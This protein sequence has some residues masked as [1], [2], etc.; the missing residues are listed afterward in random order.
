MTVSRSTVPGWQEFIDS[1]QTLPDR[2]LAKLPESRRGDPQIQ[3]EVARLALESLASNALVAIAGDGDAPQFLPAIGQVLNVGQPNADTVYKSCIITPGA[4]YRL[5]G[6]PGT[7]ALA[8]MA[9]IIPQGAP[10]A[11]MRS[12]LNL[13]DLK[14]DAQDRFDVLISA[15]RPAGYD[16]DWWEL[17]PAATQLMIRMVSADWGKEVDPTLSIERIEKPMGRPRPPAATLEERLR[18]LPLGTD[19]L[20]LMFVDHFEKLREQGFVNTLKIMTLE[21]G[22]LEG[23]FYYE[24]TY[25]LADDEAL[26]IESPIPEKCDYRSLILTNEIYETIDWY[27]N[28]SSLN[29]AQAPADSDGKLRIV[30]SARDPGV[31]NWLD[32]AG[33]PRG[34]IQG[35]W[36]GCDSQPI[37][38]VNKIRVADV[39]AAFPADV[40]TVSPDERQ[41]ILRDRRAAL[42][43]RPIW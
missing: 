26:V 13:A 43:Q 5:R 14:V 27:N 8:V 12:H 20:A 35:R 4:S 30:V 3:Q 25:D 31:L 29:G 7:L 22:A 28:H 33:H 18:R 10:G 15:E 38:T 42:M 40:A 1:L 23:Q 9:Q 21:F 24:G 32:T 19:Y 34:I 17:N 37:P 41:A 2:M 11:G 16:G 39:Q 6:R 36:T